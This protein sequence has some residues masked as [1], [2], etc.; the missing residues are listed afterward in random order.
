[1]LLQTVCLN[2][3]LNQPMRLLAYEQNLNSWY[4]ARL[5]K[6]LIIIVG[7]N[8]INIVYTNEK[9]KNTL[10]KKS[11]HIIIVQYIEEFCN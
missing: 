1:M 9:T 2:N 11:K 10:V 4:A 7:I 3:T 6:S 8:I 5:M